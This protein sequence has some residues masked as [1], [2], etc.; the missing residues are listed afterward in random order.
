MIAGRLRLGSVSFLPQMKSRLSAAFHPPQTNS[1]WLEAVVYFEGGGRWRTLAGQ[2]VI[3]LESKMAALG[4]G[5]T[6]Q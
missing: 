6:G 5:S 3:T 4:N 1:P 2:A